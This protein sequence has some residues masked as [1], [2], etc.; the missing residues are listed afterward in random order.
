MVATYNFGSVY[1]DKKFMTAVEHT[2]KA[3]DK[4]SFALW[5]L[6]IITRKILYRT[7]K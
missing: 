3:P 5:F 6:K 1:N 2:Q 7:T 4:T